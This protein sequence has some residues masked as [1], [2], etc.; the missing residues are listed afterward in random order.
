M[1]HAAQF[2]D[3][4]FSFDDIIFLNKRLQWQI[5]NQIRELRYVKLNQSSLRLVIFT[6]S[7]FAN[8]RDSSSQ[9]DYVICLT[10]S[11]HANV[12]HWS[13]VK[14]KR[15][16][17]SVLAT[18]LFAMIHSFDV[19][20]VLKVILTKMIDISISLILIIDSKFLYDCLIR[21]EITVE[22][23]LM[24]NV[25]ILRQFYERREIIEMKWI[26]EINNFVDFMTK[27]KSSFALRML[28][29]INQINLDIIEW[30]KRATIR[31]TVNQIKKDN[32][33]KDT[34]L[35]LDEMNE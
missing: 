31:D 18:E 16:T 29:D 27:S 6:D 30:V 33:I 1:S 8:N 28:I 10:D 26:H 21:L 23:R 3:S 15:V 14:C 13:S 7:F 35:R 12:L 32:Q 9:I 22:K 24:M 19:D 17:R 20:S 25:M 4:T 2:I 34:E 11:T 5:V